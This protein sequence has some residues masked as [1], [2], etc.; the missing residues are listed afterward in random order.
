MSDNSEIITRNNSN[1]FEKDSDLRW[2]YTVG[3]V[4]GIAFNGSRAFYN[5]NIILPLFL[6]HFHLPKVLIGLFA[7]VLGAHGSGIF[8]GLPQLFV[9]NR[10]EN[11]RYKKPVLVFSTTMRTLSW[12][13]IAA[14]TFFIAV[15]HPGIMLW[16][17]LLLLVLFTFM[18]GVA[19]VPLMD[20]WGKTIP[21]NMR[22]KFM[23]DRYFWGS[24]LALGT[25]FIAKRILSNEIL[26]FPNNFALL[27]L[28]AAIT[29][30]IG[31]AGLGAVREP[32]EEVHEKRQPINNFMKKVLEIIHGDQNF[33]RY[34][35]VHAL[36]EADSM[37]LPFYILYAVH[38]LKIAPALAGLLIFSQMAGEIS[39]NLLWAYLADSMGSRR[40][41]QVCTFVSLMVPLGIL[42]I[43]A[44]HQYL[45][46]PLF[47]MIG[48]VIAGMRIGTVN[49]VLDAAP[50]KDRVTYASLSG[51]IKMPTTAFPLI[52]GALAQL[53]SYPVLF[54]ITAGVLLIAFV[55]SMKLEEPGKLEHGKREIAKHV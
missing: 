41:L 49:F 38:E 51:S 19:N 27:F 6:D 7:T 55:T 13:T 15:P 50:Q 1:T 12:I 16:S 44:N 4:H 10:L 8:G 24:I 17:L 21:A 14:L 32:A 36:I 37:A 30:G 46:L 52:G 42:L 48:F 53:T 28:L 20:I 54:I 3:L 43:P 5:P 47:A 25:A 23:G 18:G 26:L 40:V 31:Y 9:A 34:M 22:G 2:N 11:K 29:M 45:L 35:I 33:R 39:S